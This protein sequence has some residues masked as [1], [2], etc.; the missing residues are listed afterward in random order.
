M[1]RSDCVFLT[2]KYF[3]LGEN[4]ASHEDSHLAVCCDFGYEKTNAR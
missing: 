1:L 3:S 2:V 4:E